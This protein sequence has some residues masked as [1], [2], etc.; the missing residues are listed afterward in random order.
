[1][2]PTTANQYDGGSAGDGDLTQVT[3]YPGGSAAARVTD[4]YY[5]WRD[6]LVATKKGVSSGESDGAN[7]PIMY[8]TLDN[9]GEVM[10]SRIYDGDGVT[11]T[12]TGGVPNAPS[13]SLLV[14]DTA[15]NFDDLGRAYQ[16][17]VFG[18]TA[19]TGA[20]TTTGL[21]TFNFFDANGNKIAAYLPGGET[22]KTS[23]DGANRPVTRSITDGGAANNAGTPRLDFADAGG[24][25]NDIVLTQTK[26][27]YD[28]DGNATLAITS[29]RLP[30]DAATATGALGTP[31]VGVRARVSYIGTFYDA[32]NFAIAREN[33][34]TNGGAA[35]TMPTSPDAGDAAHLVTSYGYDAAGNQNIIT[36]PRGVR[37]KTVFDML[38]RKTQTI[39]AWDGTS[40]ATP[41]SSTNQTTGYTYD[42][43]NHVLTRTAVMPVGTPSQTTAWVYGVAPS[44]GSVVSSNDLL[45]E[46]QYPDPSTGAASTTSANDVN[47]TYDALGGRLTMTDRNGTTHTYA[48]NT[49]GR[50]TGDSVTTLGSGVSN[51]VLRHGFTYNTLGLPALSTSYSDT[52]GTTVVNQVEDVYNGLG[53]MTGEYQATTGA[54]N[55]STTPVVAYGYSAPS[56]GSLPVSMTYPNG[57]ILHY[58]YDNNALDSAIGRVDYLADDNGAG[59]AGSHLVDYTYLGNSAIARQAFGNGNELSY[60]NTA[61]S[62]TGLDSFGRIV[63]QNYVNTASGTS[64]DDFQY[65]YDRNGN[66]LY[67]NNVVNSA[68]GELYHVSST[69]AGDDS[70]AYDPSQPPDGLRP[71]H[72][73]RKRQQYRDGGRARH[74]RQPEHNPILEP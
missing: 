46:I 60:L 31:T 72:P 27:V 6:R 40:G 66:V 58:G 12:S 68:F 28:G 41:T 70:N 3:R 7:R 32:A 9:L 26:N 65:G 23:F 19:G 44:A 59:G 42:G 29:D 17:T 36:D 54:V 18:V 53:Q 62:V 57:R 30:G 1:M 20:I 35:W 38:G 2:T 22:D 50:Q 39:T 71:W 69:T 14:A 47:F 43:N 48:F 64:T 11:I 67:K 15:N 24:L 56:S 74:R 73:Q 55:T 52:A 13:S 61:G 21:A 4:N 10:Q 37:G 63:D 33:V 51:A 5:D 8:N 25:A 45:A 49:L 16:T 34:G